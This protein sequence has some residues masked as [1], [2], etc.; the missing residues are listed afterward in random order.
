MGY[1]KFAEGDEVSDGFLA[2]LLLYFPSSEV[3]VG[4]SFSL[5]YTK[6]G[7]VEYVGANN[8]IECSDE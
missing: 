6:V 8:E 4:V 7:A 2:S 3:V 1:G 5:F